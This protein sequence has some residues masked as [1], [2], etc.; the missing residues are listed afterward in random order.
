M[1]PD[2]SPKGAERCITKRERSC[3]SKTGEVG[4]EYMGFLAHAC[5]HM[6][7]NGEVKPVGVVS[8]GW[9]LSLQ[10]HLC[11][12]MLLNLIRVYVPWLRQTLRECDFFQ[13]FTAWK[14]QLFWIW[15]MNMIRQPLAQ[16][17][18]SHLF[19]N[20]WHILQ[21][22]LT[23]IPHFFPMFIPGDPDESSRVAD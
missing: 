22:K 9:E 23:E 20:Y 14:P 2:S 13:R 7:F 11:Y 16:R 3:G 12:F 21:R 17:I 6:C 19:F 8:M 15:M 1:K 4:H 5:C 10:V 18:L